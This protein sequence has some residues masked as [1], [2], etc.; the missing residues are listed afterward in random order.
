MGIY[1]YSV[2]CSFYNHE[3]ID[4]GN[5]F[6]CVYYPISYRF[7]FHCLIYSSVEVWKALLRL[8]DESRR[9]KGLNRSKLLAS[10]IFSNSRGSPEAK[11]PPNATIP[12]FSSETPSETSFGNRRDPSLSPLGSQDDYF[13]KKREILSTGSDDLENNRGFPSLVKPLENAVAILE[14]D[15]SET[16][17]SRLYSDRSDTSH[18]KRNSQAWGIETPWIL[19]PQ[20]FSPTASPQER[21][22]RSDR[23][24]RNDRGERSD[25]GDRND[26]G[27]RSGR[28]ERARRGSSASISFMWEDRPELRQLIAED[29]DRCRFTEV[30]RSRWKERKKERKK[31]K[32][33]E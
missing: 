12:H 15:L 3:D 8:D 33:G 28:S 1:L 24:D 18:A 32:L 19:T 4:F 20:P 31:E 29:K 22:E 14:Q 5:M 13:Q 25:R 6:H 17:K 23:G 2:N 7:S 21:A 27:D 16:P 10:Q 9:Q 11:I 30:T 26:R